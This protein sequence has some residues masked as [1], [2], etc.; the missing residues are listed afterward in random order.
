M[1]KHTTYGEDVIDKLVDM[2]GE[3]LAY[4]QCAK[5]IVGSH[6]EKYDGSGYPRGLAGE[7]I[8][9]AGRVMAVA[10]VYDALTTARPY[11]RALSH[12]KTREIMKEGRGSHFDPVVFDTFLGI[13][14]EFNK[15][16]EMNRDS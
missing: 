8:P 4:L 15:I 3:Q 14:Q 9:L 13:E 6:H 10:D 1:K 11:K 5:E 7:D 16:A 2:A 12:E